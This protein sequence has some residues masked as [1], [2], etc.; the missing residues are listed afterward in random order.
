MTT[1]DCLERRCGQ[2]FDLHVPVSLKLTGSQHESSGF[3]QDLSSR[4]AFVFTDFP[5][6]QGEVVEI[7]LVMPSEI[8]LGES[9]RVRCQGTVLRVV[10]PSVGTMLGVAVHFSHYEYLAQPEAEASTDAFNRISS[11]HPHPEKERDSAAPDTRRV[12]S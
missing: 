3:T 12:A 5:L 6:A 7:T 4:G 11:L 10:Q 8:T 9:M 1:P 2:R